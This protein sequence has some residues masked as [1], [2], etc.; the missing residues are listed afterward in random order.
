[1]ASF[2]KDRGVPKAQLNAPDKGASRA[3]T[4]LLVV[5]L[6]ITPKCDY[7]VLQFII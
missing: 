3:E 1:M 2:S 4:A 7:Y 5:A 6:S